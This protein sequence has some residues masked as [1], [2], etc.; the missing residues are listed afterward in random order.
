MKFLRRT[1]LTAAIGLALAAS[2][3]AAGTIRIASLQELSGA[4]ATVGTNF[5]N[6]M[7]LAIKEINAAGGILGEKIEVTHSDTQSNPGVAKGLAQKAVD[8]GVLAVF[9]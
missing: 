4:G 1:L 2:A 9:G 3:Q 8:D 6:G 5:K 7:D